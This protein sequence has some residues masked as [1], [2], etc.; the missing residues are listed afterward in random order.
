MVKKI[1]QLLNNFLRTLAKQNEEIYG[2]GKMDCCK[3][4]KTNKR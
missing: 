2:S 1:K 3:L 4:N